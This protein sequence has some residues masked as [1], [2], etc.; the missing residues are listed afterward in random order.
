M[1]ILNKHLGLLVQCTRGGPTACGRTSPLTTGSPAPLAPPP[2]S[3]IQEVGKH[4]SGLAGIIKE[5]I[6]GSRERGEGARGKEG[7]RRRG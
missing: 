5:I 2:H 3:P 4:D 6:T 1:L 7:K